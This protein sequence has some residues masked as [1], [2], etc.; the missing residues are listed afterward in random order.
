MYTSHETVEEIISLYRQ[1]KHISIVMAQSN[2]Y[3]AITY[4]QIDNFVRGLPGQLKHYTA[5]ESMVMNDHEVITDCEIT[6]SDVEQIQKKGISIS[7]LMLP[8]PNDDNINNA[9]NK[10]MIYYVIDSKWK[11]LGSCNTLQYPTSQHCLYNI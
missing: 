1:H 3:F 9:L 5:I 6:D 11:E 10:K 7:L 2:N 8:I 4:I